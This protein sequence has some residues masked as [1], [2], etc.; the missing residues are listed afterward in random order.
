MSNSSNS[1]SFELLTTLGVLF[2]R[3]S[4][5]EEQII[6]YVS[7]NSEMLLGYKPNELV[8]LPMDCIV[9]EIHKDNFNLLRSCCAS[10]NIR[11]NQTYQANHKNGSQ[12]WINET[13]VGVISEN[14]ELQYVEGY[15]QPDKS[16]TF[17]PQKELALGNLYELLSSLRCEIR[18]SD[19]YRVAVG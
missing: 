7:P 2:F 12:V 14:G 16:G 19:A 15:L 1:F 18:K 11:V 10:K 5:T 17:T 4:A 9:N 6:L 3:C 13:A 8:G